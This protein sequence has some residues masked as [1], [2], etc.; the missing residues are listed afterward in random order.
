MNIAI[1]TDH[2]GF[3]HKEY[4]KQHLVISEFTINWIDVGTNSTE[5]T[6]Y[7]IYAQ[8]ACEAF[9][10]QKAEKAI[11]LC[12][13]GVGM[14]IVANRFHKVYAALV[15]DEETAR[16]AIEEDN[17]NMLVLPADF[18]SPEKSV[19]MIR[20]WLTSSFLHGHYQMRINEINALGGL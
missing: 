8:R 17:A 14:S 3:E 16:R 9:K 19:I 5:R 20:T 15:W 13:S 7:P 2:R 6:D 10:Q 11:L 1:A 4:I 12:G 18:I